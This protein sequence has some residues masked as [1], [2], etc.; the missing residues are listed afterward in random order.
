MG[1]KKDGNAQIRFGDGVNREFKQIKFPEGVEPLPH[2]LANFRGHVL[3]CTNDGVYDVTGGEAK[4][5]EF[6]L[7][8]VL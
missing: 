4:K 6:N 3:C 8:D 5:I 2:G 7:G 1:T